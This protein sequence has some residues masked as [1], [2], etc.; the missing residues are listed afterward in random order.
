MLS[1]NKLFMVVFACVTISIVATGETLPKQFQL[2][3]QPQEISLQEGAG[4]QYTVLRTI[5]QGDNVTRPIMGDILSVL[6]Q[7]DTIDSGVLSLQ[8]VTDSTVPKSAEGYV[9]VI[10]NGSATISARNQA[11]LFYGCQT[12][13]QL[14]EDARD[15]NAAIPACTITDWPALTYRSVHFDVKHH[16]DTMKYY[17]D[18]IDRLARYK[19]NA[20][21]FEFEDK[22]RYR[23][24][25]LVGA[26]QAIS[27]SEMAALT[28][29]ARRRHIDI[30]PLVQGLGHATFIL[31]HHAYE[32][33]RENPDEKWSF[34]PLAEGTYQ[35]LFD[36][37]RDAMEATPHSRYLH[38]GGDEVY[39]IGKC[40]RCKEM[41]EKEGVLG[42]NLYWLNRV[43]EFAQ[44][45]GRIPIFWDD[46]PLQH[47]GLYRSTH[48]DNTTVQEATELWEKGRPILNSMIE[49]FP[50]NCVYMR[51]NYT[52]AR[53]PS[54]IMALDWYR[55]SGLKA[56]I[57]TAAQTTSPLLP[58]DDRANVIKSFVELAWER[59][60]TGMLCT[61]WDDASPHMETYWRGLIASAEFSWAAGKRTLPQYEVAYLQRSFGPE[62]IYAVELY[63]QLFQISD[64]YTTFWRLKPEDIGLPDLENP[65]TWSD[66]H[67]ERLTKASQSAKLYKQTSEQLADMSKKACRN[68]YHLELLTAI[69]D[70]QIT[71]ANLI[72]ALGQCDT[73]DPTKCKTGFKAVQTT[74]EEFEITWKKLQ[75]VYARRR[76]I[77]YPENYVKD[78]YFHYASTREDMSFMILG[79]QAYHPKVRKWLIKQS[80]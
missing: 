16:L 38:V 17:Y 8:L 80:Y 55:D 79:Q 1:K 65:G 27:I 19:I 2:I 69:N 28:E 4:L 66:K 29:Y 74:M 57:A 15:T 58:T 23:R 37:Y 72:L 61:A 56:M 48:D 12:L 26:P 6:P 22:L 52:L 31:K 11:G 42:L 59:G 41:A 78:H 10:K 75:K 35:V 60:I 64:L 51:W 71:T 43:C 30:S 40:Y 14:L 18:S 73:N 47:A 68:R 54:N 25:P 7:N 24:Q 49:K 62:C 70:F 77:A 39:G 9:L 33:L 45:H 36:L 67:K 20:V 13:E 50:K 3:P 76:F 46:M 63:K 32:H 44:Q 21:I 34:C 53:Q 5:K